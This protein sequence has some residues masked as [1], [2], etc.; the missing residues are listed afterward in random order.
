MLKTQ[1]FLIILLHFTV[2]S[3]LKIMYTCQIYMVEILFNCMLGYL[4]LS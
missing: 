2:I 1:P 4:L 3:A